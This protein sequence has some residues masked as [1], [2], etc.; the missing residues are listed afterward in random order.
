MPE[1]RD[2]LPLFQPSSIAVVGASDEKTRIR[3]RLLAQ[4]LRGGYLG[5]VYPVNPARDT[6]QGLRAYPSIASLP[7]AVDLALIAIAAPAVAQAL[8]ECADRGIRAAMVFSSGFAEEGGDSAK[9]QEKLRAIA[10]SSGIV[11]AGPNSVGFLNVTLPLAATFSPAIDFAA[12]E[13][14]RGEPRSDRIAIV[15]Q[16]GG[17]GFALFNRGL[18]RKLA[19]SYVMNTGNEAD[20]DAAE[21]AGF[22]LEDRDTRVILLFLETVRDGERFLRVARRASELGKTMIAAKIGRSAAGTRAAASHT[23]SLTGAD[24]AYEA[25][26]SRWGILRAHDQDEMLDMASAAVTGRLPAG[27]RVG[28]VTISGGVGG[29]LADAL[30]AAGLEVPQFSAELQGR[31]RSYLPSYG[32]AFN[33]ID[34]TAQALE[35][36]HRLRSVEALCASDEVDAVMIVSSL[37]ADPR[38]SLEKEGLKAAI[39]ASAK[40]VFFYSYPLPSE[41]ALADLCDIGAPCYMSLTGAARALAAMRELAEARAASVEAPREPPPSARA[42]ALAILDGAGPL[43]CEYEAKRVLSAYGVVIP[44]EELARTPEEALAAARRLGFPVALK[45]QS[46]DL[47]HK[48]DAGGVALGITDEMAL[49]AA[50]QRINDE[51]SR[52]APRACILGFLVQK[53]AAPGLEAFLGIAPDG[54]F[55]PQLV[56]GLGGVFVEVFADT[57][58]APAPVGPVEARRLV[59][60][61]RGAPLFA[62][63][64][65]DRPRDIAAFA[66]LAAKVSLIASDLRERIAEIDLNP[67]LVHEDGRGV[68]VIDALI[69]QRK[70]A[71]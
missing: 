52:R 41:Q 10:H 5:E 2:L 26:F 68:T 49:R 69:V 62:S 3:G 25:A 58:M 57:A 4:I 66:E 12:L 6:V 38:L 36:D 31:V 45:I 11:V 30:V 53:M 39:A 28:I 22:M 13:R 24:A 16:S 40:P 35:N 67:V 46:P 55:G 27:R 50:W 19:F 8:T 48:T 15:S 47:P 60:R 59:G 9:L 32:S 70:R 20:I 17:L 63:L 43:L 42:E 33:P 51:A 29:W 44:P 7:K 23:A 34:I 54:T 18:K 64:R 71:S 65:G 21:A 37:A 1:P 56:L 61:L 14:M